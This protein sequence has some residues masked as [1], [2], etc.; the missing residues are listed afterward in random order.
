MKAMTLHHHLRDAHLMS[1]ASNPPVLIQL[2]D[3][4]ELKIESIR[5]RGGKDSAII[6]VAQAC[7]VL[8]SANPE[9]IKGER[10]GGEDET[11]VAAHQAGGTDYG[12]DQ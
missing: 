3:G 1:M 2:N 10:S 5:A 9:I 11:M 8:P 7:F 6:L 12:A 4:T